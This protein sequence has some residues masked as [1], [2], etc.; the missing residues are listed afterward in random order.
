M[1]SIKFNP[2]E[3]LLK[4]NK[5][6]TIR[7]CVIEDVEEL[8]KT[9]KSYIIGSEHIPIES[10]EFNPTIDQKKLW[11]QSFLNNGNSI[12]LVAVYNNQII[13]NIDLTG[14]QRRALQ[15]TAVIGICSLPII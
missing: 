4:N 1:T 12:L 13:G 5:W 14:S 15:H 8:I 10:D 6:I 2:T 9:I 11:I 7:E 3:K